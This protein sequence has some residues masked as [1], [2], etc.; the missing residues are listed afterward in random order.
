MKYFNIVQ[1]FE[2]NHEN[3]LYSNCDQ[4]LSQLAHRW[5]QF[6]THKFTLISFSMRLQI[7][8]T[9]SY[10]V[11]NSFNEIIFIKKTIHN[12]KIILHHYYP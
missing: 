9:F 2:N 1:F 4:K 6:V 8:T 7:A 5:S 10:Q 3:R 12:K 11:I